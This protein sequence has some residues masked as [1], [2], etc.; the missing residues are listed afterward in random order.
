MQK[1]GKRKHLKNR[2][3]EIGQW[4]ELV[5][6]FL[7]ILAI[8]FY[9]GML[10]IQLFYLV[11]GKPNNITD[12][13]GFINAAFD[14]VIGIEFIKML[15]KHSPSII[16]EVLLFAVA[17]QMIVEHMSPMQNLISILC[18]AILFAVRRYLFF[19]HDDEE[20]AEAHRENNKKI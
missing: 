13:S 16:V 11:I 2:V 17:R 9:A 14:L 5:I 18:I 15:C 6:S 10:C 1:V 7:I 8:I 19:D 4:L 3:Y 20:L 12:L